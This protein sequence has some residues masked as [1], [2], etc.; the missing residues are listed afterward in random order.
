MVSLNQIPIVIPAYEPD[1]RLIALLTNLLRNDMFVV[2]VDD[3][4]G[5]AYA[6]LFQEAE[7][8]LG[9]KGT[10]ISYK[11]NQGKGH[12]LKT[13]FEYV[14]SHAPM[15]LGVVTAD[16]DGQHTAE[17]IQ[18]V[19]DCLKEHPNALILGSRSFDGDSVPWK[20]RWGNRLT[21]KV[22]HYLSGVHVR[23]TQTGL[24][25]IPLA[26]AKELLQ[27][28]ADRFEFEMCMLLDCA[29]RYELVEVPIETV[30]DSVSQ[31]Q[32]HFRPVRDSFKIYGAM[33]RRFGKFVFSSLSSS[34]LDLALF[35][36][37]CAML[38][39]RMRRNTYLVAATVVARL[40]SASYNFWLNYRVVFRS[41]AS[42]AVSGTKYACLAGAQMLLSA[43]LTVILCA[44]LP[45]F[46]ETVCK[47][48]ADVLLFLFSYYI[49]QN[50]VYQRK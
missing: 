41:S 50:Y 33:A 14:I 30:Y 21:E 19:K 29:G 45:T 1:R 39:T 27:S 25:G 38:R 10:V 44:L 40:L 7:R 49:Q 42:V 4:S 43:G 26:L 31:H 36:L 46:S 32:T 2:L 9:A 17:D 24:R 28:K 23:D 35:T 18:K 12:A 8:L 5:A 22:F 48:A 20:S 37:F 3:G 13:A 15:S 34:V 6:Q 16:S 11:T 47:A